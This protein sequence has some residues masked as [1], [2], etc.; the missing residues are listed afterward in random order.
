MQDYDIKTRADDWDALEACC[1]DAR[2]TGTIDSD[3]A[4]ALPPRPAE[5]QKVKANPTGEST[6]NDDYVSD[7]RPQ[8]NCCCVHVCAD[9]G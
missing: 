1:K 6:V 5:E 9:C 4:A 7:A 8:H 2:A 3:C